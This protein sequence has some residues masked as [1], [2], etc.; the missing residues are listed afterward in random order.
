MCSFTQPNAN[1]ILKCCYFRCQIW[2]YSHIDNT[3]TRK[4]PIDLWKPNKYWPILFIP[5]C[6]LRK[7]VESHQTKP[8]PSSRC[9]LHNFQTTSMPHNIPISSLK[10]KT[11]YNAAQ[12]ISPWLSRP[13]PSIFRGYAFKTLKVHGTPTT[14]QYDTPP[15]PPD[16]WNDYVATLTPPFGQTN[17]KTRLNNWNRFV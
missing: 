16:R 6:A 8:K 11:H 13:R 7:I 3:A 2:I 4:S 1:L 5:C 9:L 12:K 15:P 14:T 17:M 10:T